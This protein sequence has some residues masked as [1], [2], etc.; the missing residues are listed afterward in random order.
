MAFLSN[1]FG[2]LVITGCSKYLSLLL[3]RRYIAL[4]DFTAENIAEV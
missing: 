1:D 4:I 3:E 2:I